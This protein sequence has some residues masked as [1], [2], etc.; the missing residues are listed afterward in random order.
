MASGVYCLQIFKFKLA[1]QVDPRASCGSSWSVYTKIKCGSSFAIHQS[2]WINLNTLADQPIYNG[3]EVPEREMA[4]TLT[5]DGGWWRRSSW[6]PPQC[7][8]WKPLHDN[9]GGWRRRG[10]STVGE[11]EEEMATR[12]RKKKQNAKGGWGRRAKCQMRV[13]KKKNRWGRRSSGKEREWSIFFKIRQG[14]LSFFA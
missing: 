4:L 14:Y 1:D 3:V 11:E 13:R 9:G 5:V 12:V 6:Q 8:S 2:M 10:N 7:T